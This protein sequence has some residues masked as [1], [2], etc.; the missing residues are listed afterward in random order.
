[1]EAVHDLRDRRVRVLVHLL[2]AHAHALVVGEVGGALLDEELQDVV[3]LLPVDRGIGRNTPIV[4]PV[5]V[6]RFIAPS[7]I[8]D[9][10]VSPSEEA[11]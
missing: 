7:A 6:R 11:M 10:P 4:Q 8:V 9:L 5:D 2:V 3:P 1:M